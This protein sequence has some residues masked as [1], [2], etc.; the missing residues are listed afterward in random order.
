[1]AA[2]KAN[3]G[4][5]FIIAS[6]KKDKKVSYKDIAAAAAKKNLTVFPIMFGRAQAM[7][8]IV[9]QAKRGKGKMARAKAAS[10]RPPVVVGKRGPGRPRK[11][12]APVV[13]G[14]FDS[15]IAV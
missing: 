14:N 4:F 1:M 11:N 13:D 10:E 8:G 6:L 7:L 15:I 12:A 5:E 9:K 3:P 2:K